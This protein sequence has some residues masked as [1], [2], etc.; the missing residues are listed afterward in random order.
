MKLFLDSASAFPEIMEHPLSPK[1]NLFCT[2][3]QLW[4]WAEDGF[5]LLSLILVPTS[6]PSPNLLLGRKNK[7]PAPNHLDLLS[8]NPSFQTLLPP[9]ASQPSTS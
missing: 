4:E 7:N 6:A 9:K 2:Q 5:G 8:V 1:Q 3:I